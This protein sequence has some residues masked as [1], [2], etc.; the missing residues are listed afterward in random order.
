LRAC[1]IRTRPAA[2]AP[3]GQEEQDTDGEVS[4]EEG[5]AYWEKLKKTYDTD[6]D[7]KL[8]AQERRKM[9]EEELKVLGSRS[10][11][12]APAEAPT[13]ASGVAARRSTGA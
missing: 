11:A 1:P 7:G 10:G 6:G 5:Q 2:R 12:V 8:D 9:I 13:G 3:L 4:R